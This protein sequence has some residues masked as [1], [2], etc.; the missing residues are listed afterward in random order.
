MPIERP[1]SVVDQ[2]NALLRQRIRDQLYMP[3]SR[4]PSESELA[5]EL[6]VSRATV[7]T[8]LAKLAAEGLILRKQG[9]GTFVN[10][11]LHEIN[12]SLGGML[13]F[14]QLISSSGYVPSIETR[15]VMWRQPTRMELEALG[16]GEE[17]AVLSLSRLF[18]ADG[19]PVIL[20]QNA[21]PAPLFLGKQNEYDGSLPIH[22]FLRTYCGQEIAYAIYDIQAVLPEAEVG[23]ML[24]KASEQPLLKLTVTF[25]SRENR[26]L[27][28]GLSYY[29][30]ARL[31][32]RLVQAW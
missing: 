13:D 9:D 19:Q 22:T 14:S 5:Q 28:W 30:D 26:P 16:V 12:T 11:R 24:A 10:Q 1:L 23:A 32:L 25:Y 3:G 2:V 8:V 6:G 17:T 18:F 7:R 21:I 20:A 4:L 29:D 31:R 15:S 27:A